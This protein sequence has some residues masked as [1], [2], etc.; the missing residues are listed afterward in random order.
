LS[1]F[2]EI[3]HLNK[4]V[5]T[6]HTVAMMIWIFAF[7]IKEINSNPCSCGTNGCI[8]NH[9]EDDCNLSQSTLSIP[10]NDG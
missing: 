3:H 6:S 5:D 7:F 10:W 1:K 8:T 4:Y 9:S 2:A